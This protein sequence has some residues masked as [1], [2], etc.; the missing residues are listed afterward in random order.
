[1][2]TSG[3]GVSCAADRN[4]RT[5]ESVVESVIEQPTDPLTTNVRVVGLEAQG[6]DRPQRRLGQATVLGDD[7]ALTAAHLVDGPLRSLEVNGQPASVVAID[8]RLDVAI[9]STA[10]LGT[11][12]A[13]P[14]PAR[15]ASVDDV[16]GAVD[17]V[18]DS[19]VIEANVVRV[20]TL[21]V[22]NLTDGVVHERPSLELD[23]VVQPGHSGAPVVD[24]TGRIVGVVV[25]SRAS[26]GV[27]YAAA[28]ES[29]DEL[30]ETMLD[31]GRTATSQVPDG[32]AIDAPCA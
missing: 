23:V 25:L 21:R 14:R 3:L 6:C 12:P 13:T 2:L 31:A 1:M 22:N 7:L 29:I 16:P 5:V 9:V 27:S 26:T 10:R 8:D 32:L 24:A 4:G 20:L 30:L 28:F 11:V 17:I 15:P 19:A 18:L